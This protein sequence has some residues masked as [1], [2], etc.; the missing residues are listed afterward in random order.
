MDEA[1]CRSCPAGGGGRVVGKALGQPDPWFGVGEGAQ[2]TLGI[3]VLLHIVVDM[4]ACMFRIDGKGDKK[5]DE[6]Q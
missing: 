1:R 6:M 5:F 3:L 2:D 4:R